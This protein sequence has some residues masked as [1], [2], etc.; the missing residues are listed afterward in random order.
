MK[1][2][3]EKI[4]D[5]FL[6]RSKSGK[7]EADRQPEFRSASSPGSSHPG[8]SQEEREC[9]AHSPSSPGQSIEA[10]TCSKLQG[11]YA[12]MESMEFLHFQVC[13]NMED[14]NNCMEIYLYLSG[15][16]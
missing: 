2:Q 9:D 14:G 13:S 10:V 1:R 6:K 8:T 3:G 11:S 12:S 7:D 16:S 4:Y 5:L 15:L